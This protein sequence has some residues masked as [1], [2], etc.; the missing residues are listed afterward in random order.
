[1]VVKT[2]RHLYSQV[3][4]FENLYRAYRAARRGKRSKESVAAFE[5]QQERELLAL[6]DELISKSY[7]PG[8][9][10]GFYIQE[11][12]RRLISAAPFRDR[13]AHHALCQVIEPIWERCFIHDSYANRVGKGTHRALDRAQEFASHYPYFLQCDVRQFFPSIDLAILRAEISRL[14]A[15]RDVLWLCDQ[16][17]ASGQALLPEEYEMAWFPGDDLLAALRPRGLPAL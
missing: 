6:Q 4:D 15:D 10:Y 13:V 8:P 3:W 11:P 12:K 5:H 7:R 14:I 1:M 9:Y 16:I 2:Y 17:L